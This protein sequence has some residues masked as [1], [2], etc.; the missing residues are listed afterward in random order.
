LP[1][2]GRH[3]GAAAKRGSVG[4][5]VVSKGEAS[6]LLRALVAAMTSLAILYVVL[7]GK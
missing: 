7:Y 2:A 5:H 6:L 1:C 4:I 3:G